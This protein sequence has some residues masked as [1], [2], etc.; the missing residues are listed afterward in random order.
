MKIVFTLRAYLSKN[1]WRHTFFT[2][3]TAKTFLS[4][5]G[6]FWLLVESVVF[7]SPEMNASL[8]EFGWW[9]FLISVLC[10]VVFR[11]PQ[12]STT[13]KLSGRDVEIELR[14]GNIFD[15]SGACVIS[16]NTTFDTDIVQKLI[17]EDSIQGQFTRRYYNS[18]SHLDLD[19]ERALCGYCF[20]S[21]T[22]K[23]QGKDRRYPIG[24][25]VQLR[26]NNKTVYLIAI[27]DINEHGN[28]QTSFDNVKNCLG[29]IWNYIGIRGDFQPIAIP[30]IGSGRARLT[31]TRDEIAKEIIR[32][33][34]AACSTK[35]FC[36]KFIIV[37]SPSDYGKLDLQ[38]LGE[39]LNYI[40]KYTEFRDH[41]EIGR[42]KGIQ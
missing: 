16:T 34:V 6:G 19:L 37:I 2:V 30:L 7:Y 39:F 38:Q 20:E 33:I 28:A 9:A 31:Q 29:E 42:G 11:R 25:I 10:T 22:E 15:I 4:F 1:Y 32:S 12:I 27:A 13:S 8:R 23:R 3:K 24:T 14:V 17:A 36:E 21:L 18:I 5:W 41:R 26:P 35:K 40:C